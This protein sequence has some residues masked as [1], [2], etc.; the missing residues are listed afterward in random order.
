MAE[1]AKELPPSPG[2]TDSASNEPSSPTAKDGKAK[3]KDVIA[4]SYFSLFR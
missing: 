2:P 3:K 4:V 1:E